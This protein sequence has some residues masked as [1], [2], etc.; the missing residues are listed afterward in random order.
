[1]FVH[2]LVVGFIL[3]RLQKYLKVPQEHVKISF[4]GTCISFKSV[5]VVKQCI[6]DELNLHIAGSIESVTIKVPWNFLYCF[7]CDI[8]IVGVRVVL[9]SESAEKKPKVP[10][11]AARV[12]SQ[13]KLQSSLCERIVKA[14]IQNVH[15]DVCQ[16][17]AQVVD[18]LGRW[19]GTQAGFNLSIKALQLDPKSAGLMLQ[20]SQIRKQLICK[21]MAVH[22]FLGT[23]SVEVARVNQWDL[24]GTQDG[25]CVSFSLLVMDAVNVC[26]TPDLVR[27]IQA[28][29]LSCQNSCASVRPMTR[30]TTSA[31]EWW[32]Y[33]FEVVKR[34]KLRYEND[35][36]EEDLENC[37]QYYLREHN[38]PW[39]GSELPLNCERAFESVQRKCNLHAFYAVKHYNETGLVLSSFQD[40]EK[41]R[42]SSA[43]TGFAYTF[44]ADANVAVLIGDEIQAVA[45]GLKCCISNSGSLELK[46]SLKS[47]LVSDA[48]KPFIMS[49]RRSQL[50]SLTV[51]RDLGHQVHLEGTV[52]VVSATMDTYA[53]EKVCKVAQRFLDVFDS[54]VW[55]EERQLK[56]GIPSK[57]S[58]TMSYSITFGGFQVKLDPEII[59]ECQRISGA[60]GMWRID[61]LTFAVQGKSLITVEHACVESSTNKYSIRNVILANYLDGVE[62]LKDRLVSFLSLIPVDTDAPATIQQGTVKDPFAA[63][64]VVTNLEFDFLRVRS[65]HIKIEVLNGARICISGRHLDC[66]SNS[67][68][69]ATLDILLWTD[70]FLPTSGF[71]G[72]I[73]PSG[74][75]FSVTCT[76]FC[77]T[78]NDRLLSTLEAIFDLVMLLLFKQEDPHVYLA[79]DYR[80]PSRIIGSVSVSSSEL[81]LDSCLVQTSTVLLPALVVD[82]LQ[83][84]AVEVSFR[85]SKGKVIRTEITIFDVVTIRLRD[86]ECNPVSL[87]PFRQDGKIVISVTFSPPHEHQ[88]EWF[89]F[90]RLSIDVDVLGRAVVPHLPSVMALW[91]HFDTPGGTIFRLK[92]L[93]SRIHYSSRP[94]RQRLPPPRSPK[95]SKFFNI[96]ETSKQQFTPWEEPNGEASNYSPGLFPLDLTLRVCSSNSVLYYPWCESDDSHAAYTMYLHLPVDELNLTLRS[97]EG[98]TRLSLD[99]ICAVPLACCSTA[100]FPLDDPTHAP[101]EEG[102]H[103]LDSGLCVKLRFTHDKVHSPMLSGAAKEDLDLCIYGSSRGRSSDKFVDH[104][105]A[106]LTQRELAAFLTLLTAQRFFPGFK[107]MWSAYS[108]QQ[109]NEVQRRFSFRFQLSPFVVH[110]PFLGAVVVAYEGFRAEVSTAPHSLL[111]LP[112][113]SV[114]LNERLSG[115]FSTYLRVITSLKTLEEE[116]GAIFKLYSDDASTHGFTRRFPSDYQS[117]TTSYTVSAITISFNEEALETMN[118]MRVLNTIF[119]VRNM[120]LQQKDAVELMAQ[121]LLSEWVSKLDLACQ[122]SPS[123]Q[124]TSHNVFLVQSLRISMGWHS[125]LKISDPGCVSYPKAELV[126]RCRVLQFGSIADTREQRRKTRGRSIIQDSTHH[127]A[128]SI[129]DSP[130]YRVLGTMD[131]GNAVDLDHEADRNEEATA[132]EVSEQ[133]LIL[134]EGEVFLSLDK[135]DELE[136][137]LTTATFSEDRHH[138]PVHSLGATLCGDSR[139]VPLLRPFSIYPELVVVPDFNGDVSRSVISKMSAVHVELT[140]TSYVLLQEAIQRTLALATSQK[141]SATSEEWITKEHLTGAPVLPTKEEAEFPSA[142][143][144]LYFG[145]YFEAIRFTLWK[146]SVGEEAAEEAYWSTMWCDCHQRELSMRAE[147]EGSFAL[148][149]IRLDDSFHD[150]CDALGFTVHTREGSMEGASRFSVGDGANDFADDAKPQP[151]FSLSIDLTLRPV[152]YLH[153]KGGRKGIHVDSGSLLVTGH[154]PLVSSQKMRLQSAGRSQGDDSG[155]ASTGSSGESLACHM[156]D[157]HVALNTEALATLIELLVEAPRR[158]ITD[159]YT[160]GTQMPEVFDPR[161]GLCRSAA[162]LHYVKGTVWTVAS[163]LLLSRTDPHGHLLCFSNADTNHLTVALGSHKF[164]L[165]GRHQDRLQAD[166]TVMIVEPGMTVTLV[167][168]CIEFPCASPAAMSSE[169]SIEEL[170]IPYVAFGDGSFLQCQS[171]RCVFSGLPAADAVAPALAAG[172]PSRCSDR[173]PVSV[174]VTHFSLTLAPCAPSVSSSAL[175]LH[176]QVRGS[177]ARQT[178]GLDLTR[179]GIESTNGPGWSSANTTL[180]S[181]WRVEWHSH[182][183]EETEVHHAVAVDEVDA[184]V[185]FHDVMLAS[186]L[187]RNAVELADK[188]RYVLYGAV[189]QQ[190]RRLLDGLKVTTAPPVQLPRTRG[191]TAALNDESRRED[192][193]GGEKSG[194]ALRSRIHSTV[195][196]V[197]PKLMLRL[198]TQQSP[199]LMIGF[200]DG[201]TGKLISHSSSSQQSLQIS[202]AVLR[203]FGKGSWE[204]ILQ[205]TSSLSLERTVSSHQSQH[206][207]CSVNCLY[208]DASF[209]ILSKLHHVYQQYCLLRSALSWRSELIR[210]CAQPKKTVEFVTGSNHG[211]LFDGGEAA[212][213]THTITNAL[214]IVYYVC[215]FKLEGNGSHSASSANIRGQTVPPLLTDVD[216][217]EIVEVPAMSTVSLSIPYKQVGSLYFCLLPSACVEQTTDGQ[218]NHF[219]SVGTKTFDLCRAAACHISPKM[220]G[221]FLSDLQFGEAKGLVVDGSLLV[222]SCTEDY[223][224]STLNA[225]TNVS[226]EA[227]QWRLEEDSEHAA[228]PRGSPLLPTADGAWVWDERSFYS[229]LIPAKK[230]GPRAAPGDGGLGPGRGATNNIHI[231]IHAKTTLRNETGYILQL[232]PFPVVPT[233]SSSSAPPLHHSD[234]THVQSGEFYPIYGACHTLTIRVSLCSR[235]YVG[236]LQLE[237]ASHSTFL[238]LQP[239][240]ALQ[241]HGEGHN[242]ETKN[243]VLIRENEKDNRPLVFYVLV[244]LVANSTSTD[245]ILLPRLTLINTV[246]L[247]VTL[248][249]WQRNPEAGPA[250]QMEGDMLRN[251]NAAHHRAED[252]GEEAAAAPPAL[253]LPDDLVF[254]GGHHGLPHGGALCLSQ[255]TYKSDLYMGISLDGD[256]GVWSTG[257]SSSIVKITSSLRSSVLERDESGGHP[258][259]VRLHHAKYSRGFYLLISIEPRTITLSV[260][261]WVCNMTPF[262]LLL[263]NHWPRR[264]LAGVCESNGIA[265]STG[266]PTILG[267][268]LHLFD[269]AFLKIGLDSAWSEVFPISIGG[270]GTVV[271][272]CPALKITRSCNYTVYFPNVQAHQPAVL[273][274]TPRWL[275]CNLTGKCLRVHIDYPGLAEAKRV[276]VVKQGRF[277]RSTPALV[278]E[279]EKAEKARADA[280]TEVSSLY[281]RPQT[282]IASCLGPKEGNQIVFQEDLAGVVPSME[283][284]HSFSQSEQHVNLLYETQ[285]TESISVDTAKEEFFNLWAVPTLSKPQAGTLDGARVTVTRTSDSRRLQIADTRSVHD[286]VLTGR[287]SVSVMQAH[288]HIRVVSISPVLTSKICIHNRMSTKAVSVRQAGNTRCST[289]PCQTNRYFWWEDP[290]KDHV[291]LVHAV[292]F[293][294]SWFLVDLRSGECRVRYESQGEG[295]HSEASMSCRPRFFV[296]ALQHNSAH[297]ALRI[298]ILVTDEPIA[299]I[300]FH[301][302]KEFSAMS[303]LSVANLKVSYCLRENGA[304]SHVMSEPD[305]ADSLRTHMVL[306]IDKL[307]IEYLDADDA[308]SFGLVV[309]QVQLQER[310][311]VKDEGEESKVVLYRALP[312]LPAKSRGAS[313]MVSLLSKLAPSFQL[314]HM[315]EVRYS[316]LKYPDGVMRLLDA[317]GSIAPLVLEL[318]DMM[319][320]RWIREV[321]HLLKVKK[322]HAQ[323]QSTNRRIDSSRALDTATFGMLHHATYLSHVWE[324]HRSQLVV[325]EE[326]VD[327]T[328]RSPVAFKQRGFTMA[329]TP[330]REPLLHVTNT[331][332]FV[333]IDSLRIASLT[334]FLTFHRHPSDPLRPLLGSYTLMLPSQM[335]RT[336]FMWRSFSLQREAE[337]SGTLRA[338]L[339]QWARDGMREQW[340]KV[341][342]LGTLLEVLRQTQR[343]PLLP[344]PPLL[345]EAGSARA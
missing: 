267:V 232:C 254:L 66:G 263:S 118:R 235:I 40:A 325:R 329:Q 262:P 217:Y 58:G 184:E 155:G 23:H 216:V 14:L 313:M 48:V 315:I 98:L 133:V 72:P 299:P 211:L 96:G 183:V 126:V 114:L 280:V 282:F 202:G 253:Q 307:S 47:I 318:S 9:S 60:L 62:A 10:L 121:D 115:T 83:G 17:D 139:F 316:S 274:I 169:S 68:P 257:E 342:K 89:P 67:C 205:P 251:W 159:S 70:D 57:R 269:H 304:V 144:L 330:K 222:L 94:S 11:S 101:G 190:Y 63:D 95:S 170:L 12:P 268:R 120:F 206:T 140:S 122:S 323:R 309:E 104:I 220:A 138:S 196:V 186:Q 20:A 25:Q 36:I 321:Q 276:A 278:V 41:A 157:C 221:V 273:F 22:A 145:L 310:R 284:L 332:D 328:Q 294:G 78:V 231:R 208:V 245:I 37:Y 131:S 6:A 53:I 29:S 15:V 92:N 289:I 160:S 261:M 137:S 103:D 24:T 275:F 142:A 55:H 320:V 252:G 292:G 327:A 336:E 212:V 306:I 272:D 215:T 175:F 301:P 303:V 227:S 128:S 110:L 241:R 88:L 80:S 277:T 136:S 344:A 312:W 238:Y 42:R 18:T 207:V 295:R 116:D 43:I 113:L 308:Q 150:V 4:L 193:D 288:G 219:S 322:L 161:L 111:V 134:E 171:V 7:R 339:R 75:A 97:R 191:E 125:V 305:A 164:I 324:M 91:R 93:P 198:S 180:L 338:Q 246:G 189:E 213:V 279:K 76:G 335:D 319:V 141:V 300:F 281:L 44:A 87:S 314:P 240:A 249:V 32:V 345:H 127:L 1:M 228:T 3:K 143:R 59:F 34:S 26:I 123:V 326:V 99:G 35:S 188:K 271:A 21:E 343:V 146:V 38:A 82:G 201:M 256:S 154:H 19:K 2:N 195:V 167:G 237:S 331:E 334:L 311:G 236:T 197:V 132:A 209:I 286:A 296:K 270:S 176:A 148:Q 340:T 187:Y 50:L 71:K 214:D 77:L 129:P 162:H 210:S 28:L 291:L 200:E 258:I 49:E 106:S 5:E 297:T 337:T 85:R 225:R 56:V 177:W 107:D 152:V 265:P 54:T 65:T 302:C 163:D 81:I 45:R 250:T 86:V 108:Y 158:I 166:E 260:G 264:V 31:K 151:L 179:V 255:C 226:Y 117:S 194:A 33:C 84:K 30:P 46:T 341:T 333:L 165:D 287:L 234:F 285:C 109:E 16:V 172:P 181:D 192:G 8:A 74:V 73:D 242:M 239:L 27:V 244:A 203:V 199:L 243:G 135:P 153:E 147:S 266:A 130:L 185:T 293:K 174:S 100:L 290:R 218:V 173:G 223:Y 283:P 156:G 64:V 51:S 248:T 233:E 52:S 61:K 204:N 317:S 259:C 149:T 13:S 298:T 178:M 224:D 182:R 247:P 119:V 102:A 69:N 90:S 112:S 229:S 168:G 79:D 230:K 124:E 105:H 39:C